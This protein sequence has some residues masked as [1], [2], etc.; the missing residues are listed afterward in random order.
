MAFAMKGCP[1]ARAS[2]A[3]APLKRTQ[4]APAAVRGASVITATARVDKCSKSQIMV[5]PSILSANFA[6][7]GDQVCLEA[8]VMAS[9]RPLAPHRP[10]CDVTRSQAVTRS[11]SPRWTGLIICPGRDWTPPL[12]RSADGQPASPP[13]VKAVDVAGADW[14]HVDV[15]DGRFVPNITIGPLVVAALRPVTDKVIDCHLARHLLAPADPPARGG[16]TAQLPACH[17]LWLPCG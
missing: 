3:G 13:Q 14:I 17:I 8:A 2:F 6:N 15:M 12:A 10:R 4:R 5:A 16:R 7:L 11:A 9:A 1:V